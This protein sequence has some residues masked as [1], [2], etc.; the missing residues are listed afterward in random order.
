MSDYLG[1]RLFGALAFAFF[2]AYIAGRVVKPTPRLA[3]RVRPYTASSRSM[4]G[5]LPDRAAILQTESVGVAGVAQR[6]YRPIGEAL[7]GVLNRTL[8]SA[9]DEQATLLKLRQA[10][11]M[12]DISETTRVHEWR[13]RQIGA[14]LGYGLAVG[15]TL[16]LVKGSPSLTLAGFVVGVIMGVSRK[17]AK[18]SRRIEDRRNR[19]RTELY[20]VNQLLAIYLRTSGSPTLAAQRLVRRGRGA[21]IDEMNEALRL[22]ARGMP[23][24]KAFNRIAESTPEPLAAR[25][26]K[27][28]ASGSE[29]GAD[30]A[31]AL[32][33]LSEDVRDQ[34]RNEV[35]RNATKR[36]GAMLIPILLFLA[37]VMLLFIGAPLPSIIFGAS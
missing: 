9:W 24:A 8:G 19:I 16:Q 18:V 17:S 35:R 37:P 10:N 36:Q 31:K 21:V 15:F 13:L 11:L 27:L 3:K 32:L 29:R 26:Y 23:A 7:L 5:Q 1:L 34:R 6:I 20:T 30:L 25:T 28:L 33:S 14:G 2:V 12:A 22:H 4:L